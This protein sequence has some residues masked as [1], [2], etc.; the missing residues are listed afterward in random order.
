MSEESSSENNSDSGGCSCHQCKDA[1]TH[2]PGFFAFGEADKTA[3]SM[4]ITLKE[5]FDKYLV[6]DWQGGGSEWA[7]TK[8]GKYAILLAPATTVSVTGHEANQDPRGHC[9]FFEHQ[10]GKCKIH[11]H[12]KPMECREYMH[13]MDRKETIGLHN[14]AAKTWD[15]DEAK[16][17]INQLLGR[18]PSIEES[19][20]F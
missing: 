1:C 19:D 17:Q 2:R 3:E 10:T 15:N 11:E 8:D 13:T 12:G 6:V 7:N 16:A 5:F 20:Y 14:K 4:G 9:I 18:E